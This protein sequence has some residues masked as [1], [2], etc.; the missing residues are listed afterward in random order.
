MLK[1]SLSK[2][3]LLKNFKNYYSTFKNKYDA[4]I[5]GGG[6]N[7]L[8]CANYLADSGKSVLVLER[9]HLIGGAAITEE[10][11]P[12]F[13]F[14]RASYLCSLLRKEIIDELKLKD[15]GLTLLHRN[16]K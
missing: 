13:K 12:G 14:S 5:V 1:R 9:R 6:H 15:Y 3:T 10:I 4:I 8:V 16:P 11:I 2:S 7:G